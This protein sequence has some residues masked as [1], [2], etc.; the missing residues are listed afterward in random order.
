M[1]AVRWSRWA[2]PE[3]GGERQRVCIPPGTWLAG[4]AVRHDPSRGLVDLRLQ[5]QCGD[6]SRG[7]TP[8][9]LEDDSGRVFRLSCN[10]RPYA[11]GIMVRHSHRQGLVNLRLIHAGG[12]QT[13]W[14][15]PHV[16]GELHWAGLRTGL[17]VAGLEL[18]S[19]PGCGIINA[20]AL[21]SD[22]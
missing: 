5:F 14:A 9:A 1:M 22:S 4:L 6:G 12:V 15:V 2:A 11:S 10:P 20:R 7:W 16:G 17:R 13:E 8:W 3:R 19:Q 18:R 21:A